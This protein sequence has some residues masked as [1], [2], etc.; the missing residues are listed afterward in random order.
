MTGKNGFIA[1]EGGDIWYNIV[2]EAD[3][4]PLIVLHGGPGYPHDYLEPL[5]DLSVDRPVV[6]YDQ[7]GCGNSG[8]K[9]D[10]DLWTVDQFVAEL[11]TLI[12][13]L[14]FTRFH[15]LGHSWGSALAYAF[16]KNNPD[17]LKSIVFADPYL[18]SPVWEEDARKLLTELSEADQHALTNSSP[19]SEEFIQATRRY[20]RKF[21]YGMDTL[22]EACQRS[23]KKM[24]RALYNYM[25]GPNELFVSGTLKPFDATQDLKVLRTPSLFIC[26]RFDEATPRASEYFAGL[27]PS[28]ECVVLENS[29]HH[30]HWTD[31]EG[32]M[33]HVGAF[34]KK[35]D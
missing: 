34:L 6:F 17:G 19:T 14:N 2:G 8:A 32:Y 23:S 31:R 9:D 11:D 33:K 5:E 25:W 20:Y 29:A 18:S 1:V 30:S 13:K 28:A 27:M 24:N 3:R 22:P 15:L 7:L 16:A 26:G 21:V 4:A 12:K 10:P 35:H